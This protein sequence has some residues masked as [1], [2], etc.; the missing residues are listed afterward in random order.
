MHAGSQSENRS[1]CNWL[2]WTAI[3]FAVALGVRSAHLWQIAD[4]PFFPCKIGDAETYDA[5]GRQIAAGDWLGNGVFYQAPLYPYFLGTVYATL[6]DDVFVVR[7]V[8]AVIGALSCVFLCLAGWRLFSKPAGIA[9]GLMLAVYAPAIFF[10][11]L[12][13]KSVL[14]VFFLCLALWIFSGVVTTKKLAGWW[15]LGLLIAAL[16]LTRENALVLVVPV[17]AWAVLGRWRQGANESETSLPRR[18]A[19]AG[20]FV[21]GLAAVLIPVALR[22]KQVGGEFHLT[23]SQFGPNFYIGN[24]PD[25]N[26]TYQPL[27]FG[28]G[29]AR[30]ERDDATALAE[31]AEGRKLTPAEVSSYYFGQSIEYISSQPLD[32]LALM[33]KKFALTWNAAEMVD[34][35]DQYT[36]AEHSQPLRLAGY[37]GHFGLLVPMAL[38]GVCVTW[39]ERRKL[40]PLYLMM[41][42]LAA[43]V[44]VFFVFARYR[45]PLVPLLILFAAAGLTRFAGFVATRS[46]WRIETCLLMTVAATVFCNLP[47]VSLDKMRATT[48]TNIGN[49]LAVDGRF[50]EAVEHYERALRLAPEY[51]LAH[52]S[53]GRVLVEQGKMKQAEAHYRKALLLHPDY[54][55]ARRNLQRLEALKTSAAAN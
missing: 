46:T 47:L 2:F 48:Y 52:N 25:A 37:A 5:W 26:G 20:L 23:T 19:F 6:G 4:A 41:V 34:S 40:W 3:V 12:I 28:R 21:A 53:L 33:G 11:G 38:L 17:L 43:S 31:E 8:Q 27:R 32:W 36:Y 39:Q 54:P 1:L 30:F 51:A 44:V 45:F 22:N 55:N 10:D 7:K 16:A 24:N 9:A 18:L 50:D 15:W 13:Q 29:H 14:D 35:E 49:A 42:L